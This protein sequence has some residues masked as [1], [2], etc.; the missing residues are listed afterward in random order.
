MEG[1]RPLGSGVIPALNVV[2]L[3]WNDYLGRGD[4]YVERLRGMIQEHLTVPHTFVEVT[5][6]DLPEGRTGWF[7]KLHLLEMF[8]GWNLFLDLDVS[9]TANINHLFDIA[10]TDPTR[11][12]ARND[13]SYPL[14]PQNNGRE[15]TI[16]SSVMIWHGRKDMSGAEALISA[17]HGDQG[18]ITQLFWPNGIGLLPDALVKSYKYHVQNGHG[19]APII[20]YHGNPKPHSLEGW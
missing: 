16:N 20:V 18:I 3:N 17:T 8:D 12:W 9:I 1:L 4:Q 11:I 6:R 15:S 7:N 19:E 13:F 2:C 5:E 10:R 14:P